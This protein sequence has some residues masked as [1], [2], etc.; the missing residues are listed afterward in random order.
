[1]R[2][3]VRANLQALVRIRGTD[4]LGRAVEILGE[5]VDFSRKGLGLKV[6]RDLFV[7]G[8]QV[9]VDMPHRMVSDAVIQ[10][11]RAEAE[12]GMVRV[13]LR[14]E[15]PRTNLGFRIAAS[16]L[17]AMALLSQVSY[18]KSRQVPQRAPARCTMGLADMKGMLQAA[19]GD[20]YKLSSSEMAFVQVQHERMSHEEFVR[21]FEQAD[22]FGDKRKT[23]AVVRWHRNHHQAAEAARPAPASGAVSAASE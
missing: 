3:N 19:L 9:T 23:Q 5:S 13:G 2:K 11:K 4:A 12:T 17:L 18:A 6:D 10:W 21:A 20:Y 15:N 16:F 14:L 1:M 7:P 8:A 22:F